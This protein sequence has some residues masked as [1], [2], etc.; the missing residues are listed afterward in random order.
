MKVPTDRSYSPTHEWFL[1]EDDT[2]TVGIT[3]YAADELTDI[4]FVE[5][6]EIGSEV[7]PDEPCG[8]IESVKAFS[9]LYCAVKGKVIEI[10][11]ALNDNP[12]LLNEDAFDDGWLL[13]IHT[14]DLDALHGLMNAKAYQKHIA[15]GG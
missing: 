11:D 13:K 1:A 2:V 5:L 15:A 10:N 8:G 4:T 6:P 12:G 9:E 14:D 7:G 3:Q